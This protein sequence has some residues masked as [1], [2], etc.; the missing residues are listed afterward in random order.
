LSALG[1]AISSHKAKD[2]HDNRAILDDPSWLAVVTIA[3]ITRRQLLAVTV[4]VIEQNYLTG[5]TRAA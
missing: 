4:D 1:E 2:D 3:E 5:R